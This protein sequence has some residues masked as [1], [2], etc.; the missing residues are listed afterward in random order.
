LLQENEV[1]ENGIKTTTLFKL[2][3]NFNL[4]SGFQFNETGISNLTDVNNP[5]FR[6]FKKE[7]IR[8][9]SIFSE[10]E[11]VSKSKNTY[12]NFG[13]R[14]NHFDKFNKV[15]LEPRMSFNHRFDK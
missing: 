10:T 14:I 5:T 4:K 9:N 13:F 8:T 6:D 3:S 11:Y 1:T 7:V 15:L 2:S 12:F